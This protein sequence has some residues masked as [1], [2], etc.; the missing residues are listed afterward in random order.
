MFVAGHSRHDVVY[1]LY[2]KNLLITH[3]ELA[4]RFCAT[5]IPVSPTDRHLESRT[6]IWP[7]A[8]SAFKNDPD[9]R[10]KEIS[11]VSAQCAVADRAS[12]DVLKRYG[13]HYVLWNEERD[14]EWKPDRFKTKLS[15]VVE[16]EG[17]SLWRITEAS[18]SKKDPI[19]QNS[20][21]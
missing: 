13:V 15:P 18:N 2:M 14:P 10:K 12:A 7:D 21:S 5:Q 8:D 19:R 4:K 6:L 11:L 20:M 3:Q 1:A 9:V 17:W 16:G